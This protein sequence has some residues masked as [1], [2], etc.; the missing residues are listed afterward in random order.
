MFVS[1]ILAQV[2]AYFRYRATVNELS[3]LSDREL[4]DFGISRFE[5]E[6]VARQSVAA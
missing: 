5:I 2:R 1:F 3:A 4:N 6:S